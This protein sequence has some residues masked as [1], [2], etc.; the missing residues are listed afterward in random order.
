M[1]FSRGSGTVFYFSSLLDLEWND[2]PIRG[3]VVPLLYR[4]IIL[5]GTDEINTSAVLINEP[6]L[7]KVLRYYEEVIV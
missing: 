5:S 2:L 3:M 4:L 6:K 1:E 7:I